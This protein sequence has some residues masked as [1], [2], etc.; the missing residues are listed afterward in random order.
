MRTM[1]WSANATLYILLEEEE[2][3]EEESYIH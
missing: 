2:E 1:H 3:E